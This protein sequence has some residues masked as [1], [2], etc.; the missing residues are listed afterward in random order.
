MNIK[1]LAD[2][3][4]RRQALTKV[5]NLSDR[6]LT[7]YANTISRTNR[8]K[9]K[10]KTSI[11]TKIHCRQRRA[12]TNTTVGLASVC[13]KNAIG[14]RKLRK[15]PTASDAEK[16]EQWYAQPSDDRSDIRK[17]RKVPS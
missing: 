6:Q 10:E 8:H 15:K 3:K 7:Q 14:E 9:R 11:D 2:I 13:S 17:R 5:W 16:T 4:T 12:K 1:N